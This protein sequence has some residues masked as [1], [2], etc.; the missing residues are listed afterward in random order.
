MCVLVQLLNEQSIEHDAECMLLIGE[1]QL[2]NVQRKLHQFDILVKS[3]K[4]NE[5]WGFIEKTA[6]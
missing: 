4:G 6:R 5:A 2:K 1:S 3:S